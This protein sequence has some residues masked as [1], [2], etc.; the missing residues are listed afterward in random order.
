M[1][2]VNTGKTSVHC[3]E[4]VQV[5]S[6]FWSVFPCIR[7]EYGNLGSKSPYPVRIQ[8]NTDQRKTPYFHTFQAMVASYKNI[9]KQSKQDT[10][11]ERQKTE[12]K[13]KQQDIKKST[14]RKIKRQQQDYRHVSRS[15]LE[16]GRFLG[17]KALR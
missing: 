1:R 3:V 8:E 16:Q 11:E 4:S 6:F 5:R 13:Q 10:D 17:I 9:Q 12:S 7:I 15:F 2:K 14:Q